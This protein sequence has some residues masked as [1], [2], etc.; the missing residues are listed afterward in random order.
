[1]ESNSNSLNPEPEIHIRAT[2]TLRQKLDAVLQD[3]RRDSEPDFT[4]ERE[5]NWP[6]HRSRERSIAVT[7]IQEAIMW[8]GM[9]LKGLG[10]PTPYP[11]SYNPESPVVEPTADGLTL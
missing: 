1:M 8:L 10:T 4:G 9:D 3:L 5:P 11:Q 7:K 2:K 6:V